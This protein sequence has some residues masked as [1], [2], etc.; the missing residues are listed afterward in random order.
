[1]PLLSL[2]SF[3]LFYPLRQE[4][5]PIIKGFSSS[6]SVQLLFCVSHFTCRCVFFVASVGEV[7]KSPYSFTI[8]AL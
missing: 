3:L 2:S 7:N 6:A 8:W 4:I 5:L 1:M